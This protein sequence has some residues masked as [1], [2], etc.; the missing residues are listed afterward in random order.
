M[1]T[2]VYKALAVVVLHD[3]AAQTKRSTDLWTFNFFIALSPFATVYR[4]NI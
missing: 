3:S 1:N 2:F 4:A